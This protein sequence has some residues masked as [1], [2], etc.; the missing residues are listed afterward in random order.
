MGSLIPYMQLY[1]ASEKR[2]E[3]ALSKSPPVSRGEAEA[4]GA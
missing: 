3:P 2:P 1:A 4:S